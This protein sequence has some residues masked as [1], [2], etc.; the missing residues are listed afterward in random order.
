[1]KPISYVNQIILAGAVLFGLFP[2][3][4]CALIDRWTGKSGKQTAPPTEV[5]ENS[6]VTVPPM[7]E[8]VYKPEIDQTEYLQKQA[9]ELSVE[10][11]RLQTELEAKEQ[12]I[13]NLD[14]SLERQAAVV[15]PPNAP[16]QYNPVIKIEGVRV[17]PRDGET[18][19]I[20]IDDTVLFSQNTTAQLLSS[21]DDVL[22]SVVREIRVNYPNNVIGIE[23]HADPI[24]EN[25]QSPMYT[26]E[27]TFRKAN[28]VAS[29]LLEQRKVTIKQIKITGHGSARPLPGARPEK[30]N[31]IEMVV[32]P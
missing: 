7:S 32:F 15:I 1:M 25:P 29:C 19:R 11:G 6:H 13:R 26:L 3:G 8:T 9:E 4:G 22:S 20:A 16:L 2:L 12:T 23:G 27:L 17:L 10:V 31:R 5:S 14:A 28:A 30:N 18:I 21:A 24:L